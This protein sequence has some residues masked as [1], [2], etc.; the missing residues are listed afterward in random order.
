[1]NPHI[2][3]VG[4]SVIALKSNCQTTNHDVFQVAA[5]ERFPKIN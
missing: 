4:R 5:I 2:Q 3:I 1:M